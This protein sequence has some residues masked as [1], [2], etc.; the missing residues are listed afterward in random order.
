MKF[1]K[2]VLNN[3]NK[4]LIASTLA[5][6]FTLT[7]LTGC[8]DVSINDIKY[9]KN[10]QGYV[11]GIDTVK[12]ETLEYC[13]VYKVRNI[14]EERLYYTICLR[15]DFNGTYEVKYYDIFNG[16]ELKY[17]DYTFNEVETLSD[18]LDKE[19]KEYTEIELKEILDKYNEKLNNVEKE[20]NVFNYD[21]IKKCNFYKVNDILNN[22][23]YYTIAFID[24]SGFTYDIFTKDNLNQRNFTCD[25]LGDLIPWLSTKNLIKENYKEEELKEILKELEEIKKENQK[26]L[27]KE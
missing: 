10:N 25:D 14:K 2:G 11:Q 13:G 21:V 6:A 16:E 12:K 1:S 22:K 27:V 23:E 9:I 5:V 17:S 24:N 20:Q 18:Y 8:K 26:K 4:K 7:S 3:V 15:D 19:K